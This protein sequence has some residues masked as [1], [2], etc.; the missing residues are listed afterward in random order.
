MDKHVSGDARAEFDKAGPADVSGLV[1]DYDVPRNE[2]AEW[3]EKAV[4]TPYCYC[5][6]SMEVRVEF[7]ENAPL[8]QES[9][10]DFLKRKKSGV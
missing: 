10:T 9:F 1:F 5:V 6:G 2:R 7:T 3:L 8:L 4:K